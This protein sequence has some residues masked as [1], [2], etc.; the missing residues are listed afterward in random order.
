MA[1]VRQGHSSFY[2]PRLYTCVGDN[3]ILTCWS[4]SKMSVDAVWG[5]C[6]FTR[7]WSIDSKGDGMD[8]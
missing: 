4:T 5:M 3:S 1:Q 6:L 7:A 8:R 2:R